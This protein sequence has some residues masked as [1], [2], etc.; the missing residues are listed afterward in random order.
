MIAVFAFRVAL[1]AWFKEGQHLMETCT[2]Y[3]ENA[4]GAWSRQKYTMVTLVLVLGAAST[5]GIF[6]ILF[7]TIYSDLAVRLTEW[8]NHREQSEYEASIIIKEFIFKFVN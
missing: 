4:P 5:N 8:E 3:N 6:I 7:N 1:D 2:P